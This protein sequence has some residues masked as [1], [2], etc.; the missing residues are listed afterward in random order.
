ME[1][2]LNV[3]ETSA[4]GRGRWGGVPD[5]VCDPNDGGSNLVQNGI[6]CR[7]DHPELGAEG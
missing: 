4:V 3:T 2:H 6:L 5:D 7:E 1:R